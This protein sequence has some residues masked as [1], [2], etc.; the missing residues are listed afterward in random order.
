L[1][2][3]EEIDVLAYPVGENFTMMNVQVKNIGTTPVKVMRI[4]ISE[5]TNQTSQF[6]NETHVPSLQDSIPPATQ[7]TFYN[8]SLAAFYSEEMLL[9]VKLTTERGRTFASRTNPIWISEGG[10]C[11]AYSFPYNIQFVFESPKGQGTWKI[12]GEIEVWYN[13]TIDP[14]NL[15]VTYHKSTVMDQLVQGNVYLESVGIPYEGMYHIIVDIT[16]PPGNGEV[17]NDN[18][19]VTSYNPMRWLYITLA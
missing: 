2:A 11:G 18:L 1:K 3:F 19:L 17:F 8:L 12:E 4:W 13:R 10:W 7:T 9:S 5:I 16:N 6:W 14:D 15:N